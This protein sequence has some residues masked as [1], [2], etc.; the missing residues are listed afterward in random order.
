MTNLCPVLLS[1]F[2]PGAQPRRQAPGSALRT[3]H[4]S[5]L[6]LMGMASTAFSGTES[7]ERIPLPP[8]RL[9][10]LIDCKPQRQ[11]PKTSAE[12]RHLSSPSRSSPASARRETHSI[13]RDPSKSSVLEHTT[14]LSIRDQPY[15]SYYAIATRKGKFPWIKGE[16]WGSRESQKT[17]PFLRKILFCLAN[18]HF[19]FASIKQTRLILFCFTAK[20]SFLQ[21]YFK[22]TTGAK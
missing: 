10:A 20:L 7:P 11:L 14:L 9:S 5:A 4:H 18:R 21:N 2:A 16:R 17:D 12:N 19:L 1:L 13:P 22:S 15:F 3:P 6:R 8:G